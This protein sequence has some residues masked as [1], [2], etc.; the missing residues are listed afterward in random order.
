M[1]K[2]GNKSVQ[3]KQLNPE[4]KIKQFCFFDK[5]KAPGKCK[6]KG[7]HFFLGGGGPKFGGDV[8]NE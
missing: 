6:I 1:V 8:S 5:R 7:F 4:R 2:N 3:H